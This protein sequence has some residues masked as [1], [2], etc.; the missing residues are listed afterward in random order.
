MYYGF[1][2][3]KVFGI[4]A[5]QYPTAVPFF[6]KAYKAYFAGDERLN[7]VEREKIEVLGQSVPTALPFLNSLWTDLPPQDN[8]IYIKLK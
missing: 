5:D 1:F 2:L 3:Q 6:T 8:K 4:P 7:S